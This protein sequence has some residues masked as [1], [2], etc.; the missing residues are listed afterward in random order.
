M[1]PGEG[2]SGVQVTVSEVNTVPVAYPTCL[3]FVSLALTAALRPR[4]LWPFGVGAPQPPAL[5]RSP[6]WPSG[7]WGC[8]P[9]SQVWV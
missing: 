1:L 8:L 4:M 6:T 7:Q 9:P 2:R 5:P 3:S